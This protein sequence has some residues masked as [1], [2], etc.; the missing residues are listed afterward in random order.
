VQLPDPG[1]HPRAYHP[2]A[3]FFPATFWDFAKPFDQD[4]P[5]RYIT[6]HRLIKQDP[7]AAVSE[8][9]E[10][11]VYYLDAAIPAPY[12]TA[13]REGAMWW[14]QVFEAAGFRDAFRVE[15]MPPDMDPMDARYHVIQWVHRTDPGYSI[16]PSLVDPRT[17]QIIKA[18]VRM[19]TYRSQMDYDIYAGTIPISGLFD[20]GDL[21]WLASLA[22]EADAEAFVM[23]RRR[24]HTAHEVGHTLGLAHNFA[25]ASYG[26]AS[27]MD[28]PAPLI[29][30]DGNRLDVRDAYR[31]GPG[32]WDTLAIRYGYTEFAAEQEAAGLQAILDEARAREFI[33]ITN[34]DENPAGSFPR[35]T[36]WVNGTDMVAELERVMQVRR[37][38]LDRFDE[39]AIA[40]GEP[41]YLLGTRLTRAYLHHRF[42]LGAALKTVGG[43]EYHYAVR[44]DGLVPTTI[45]PGEQQR[46]ALTRVLDVLEPDELA[47]REEVLHLLAPRP[48]GY[49]S[50]ERRFQSGAGPA[51]DQLAMARALA[52]DVVSGLLNP[53]R[54]GRVAAFS[55]R[56]PALPALGEVL[57]TLVERTWEVEPGEEHAALRRVVQRVVVDEL[58]TLA[59]DANA[60]VE[61]RAAA[62][63]SLNRLADIA[64]ERNPL[65]SDDAAHLA[66]VTADIARFLGRTDDQTQRSRAFPTPPGDP[67]GGRRRNR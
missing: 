56:D 38:M 11:I 55:A 48:P 36:T 13:F 54:L 25:T 10:P 66:L 28:Y 15:D 1:Y 30:R 26:R 37:L 64:A 67:I 20:E 41:M 27:V 45:V 24:Q 46:A 9:I 63:W 44:G 61:A 7:S 8:P 43:M 52:Q 53:Q 33:F 12:R 29:R 23:A 2:Q 21:A 42:T 31:D 32:A 4:Y 59:S 34:P 19:D 57:G 35:A 39:T 14:N 18:A 22:Q 60:A 51:F 6:R 47:V 49:A 58:L 5:T 16:G 50:E 62:E 3:G 17:G 40:A 65:S